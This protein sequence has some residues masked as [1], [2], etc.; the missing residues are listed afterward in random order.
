[1]AKSFNIEELFNKIP[2]HN[3]RPDRA[4]PPVGIQ[5][6]YLSSVCLNLEPRYERVINRTIDTKPFKVLDAPGMLDDYYLNLLDWNSSDL[7]SIGLNEAVYVYNNQT[8]NVEEIYTCNAQSNYISSVKSNNNVVAI[9]LSDGNLVFYDLEK[10]RVIVCKKYHDTRVSSLS[11]NEN[12]L[13]S[14]DKKGRLINFDVRTN[15]HEL[16][17]GHTQEICGLEWSEDRKFL[18]SGGNDND[19]RVWKLGHSSSR[20][21]RGH[22]SAVRALAWCPW[23]SA[24]LASG[25]GTKDK[26]I[27][28]WDV[29]EERVERSV[30]TSSQV[31]SLNYLPKYKELISSHGYTEN[32]IILWKASTMKKVISFGKHDSRVLH[33][34]LSPDKTV[35]A[36]VSAD[37]SL[38]FWRIVDKQKPSKKRDSVDVR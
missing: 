26:C 4:H 10:E 18:A 24:T 35:L 17:L 23:R 3:I 32:D 20:L 6:K 25:G 21:L 12:I 29:L 37:E 27:K 15:T 7:I 13:S 19:I 38:K 5:N 11:W 2:K 14:G 36:S 8:K 9:G 33:V 16:L 28:F 31:C 34:A 1:M 30:E 22:K